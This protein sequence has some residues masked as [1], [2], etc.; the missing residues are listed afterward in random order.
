MGDINSFMAQN[1]ERN[2]TVNIAS[3]LLS[4]DDYYLHLIEGR[5]RDVNAL[6]NRITKDNKHYECTL[7]RYIDVKKREFSNWHAEHV[8]ISEFDVGN[9]NLLL[10]HGKIDIESITSSQAVTM[11]R[12]IH[13]HLQVKH[14]HVVMAH[15]PTE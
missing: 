4:T 12:R 15:P 6:Y 9:I 11:I 13:A 8:S 2:K 1:R 3:I 14:P 10:P 5:R 7:L